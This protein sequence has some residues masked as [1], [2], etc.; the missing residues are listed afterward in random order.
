M[1]RFFTMQSSKCAFRRM[2]IPHGWCVAGRLVYQQQAISIGKFTGIIH[3]MPKHRKVL[4]TVRLHCTFAYLPVCDIVTKK[5]YLVVLD[6]CKGNDIIRR[7]EEMWYA[8]CMCKIRDS[9]PRQNNIHISKRICSVK[10]E[11]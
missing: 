8:K 10:W 3:F 4:H 6:R 11:I 9:I 7:T 5:H 2:C 1:L